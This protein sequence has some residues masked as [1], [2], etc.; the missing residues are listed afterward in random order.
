MR[1]TWPCFVWFSLIR[2]WN[3]APLFI[4]Y[5]IHL[6]IFWE[7]LGIFLNQ[8]DQLGTGSTG[9]APQLDDSVSYEE[10]LT[11]LCLV[12]TQSG[13]ELSTITSV[14][15]FIHLGI[16]W[17]NLGIIINRLYWLGIGSTCYVGGL[18]AP[19]NFGIFRARIHWGSNPF[20][21]RHLWAILKV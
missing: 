2:V 5:S 14:W 6:G 20:S 9:L 18:W 12:P 16:F 11:L 8:L 21:M 19:L 10:H 1:N 15:L 17:Q 13:L 4:F 7:N 3:W